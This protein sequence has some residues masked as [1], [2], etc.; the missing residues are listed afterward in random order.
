MG[1]CFTLRDGTSKIEVLEMF[2]LEKDT[3]GIL[4]DP[5]ATRSGWSDGHPQCSSEQRFQFALLPKVHK[6]SLF[7]KSF[8]NIY[9]FSF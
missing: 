9:I 2:I 5:S 4:L 1:L 6:S 7:R 3:K 8:G